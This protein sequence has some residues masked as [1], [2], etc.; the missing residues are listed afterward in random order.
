MLQ[1]FSLYG[2][3]EIRLSRGKAGPPVIGFFNCFS[4][5]KA[6]SYARPR[7]FVGGELSNIE[8]PEYEPALFMKVKS[9]TPIQTLVAC[10]DPHVFEELTGKSSRELVEALALLDYNAGRKGK[11]ARSKSIDFAQ[12][13]CGYQALDCFVNNPN[14]TLFLEAKALELV[15]L[16]LKQL[17]FLT[18]T[19][20]RKQAVDHNVEKVY[21]ACE[22]LRKEMMS[23]PGALDLARRVGINHNQLVQGFKQTLGIPPFEYLRTIRLEKAYNMIANHECNITEAAFNVG[24]S[25]LSH[26]SRSFRKEFGITPKAL[27]NKRKKTNNS[28]NGLRTRKMEHRNTFLSD[29]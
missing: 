5:V 8:L 12:K 24:L 10:L 13:I 22:I 18:G 6:V 26:F 17:G 14:E 15:A 28:M 2:E 20:P 9:N 16:Q 7:V 11:P 4:G 19:T 25:S 3:G 1:D 27:S 23:P 21:Y 29:L